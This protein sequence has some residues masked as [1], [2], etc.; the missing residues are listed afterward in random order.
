MYVCMHANAMTL[1][2]HMC[3]CMYA[4]M[5]ECRQVGIMEIFVPG[6]G[7]LSLQVCQYS[8]LVFFW[9]GPLILVN[10]GH[11]S[12]GLCLLML[13]DVYATLLE[14]DLMV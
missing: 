13:A 2:V 5:H 7:Y 9:G 14:S 8:Y 11:C 1:C 12:V 10:A 6:V 3:E 4:S